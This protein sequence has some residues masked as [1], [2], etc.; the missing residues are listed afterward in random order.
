MGGSGKIY[1]QT[2][3][4]EGVAMVVTR[5][6]DFAVWQI[7]A[8]IGEPARARILLSLLDGQPKASAELAAITGLRA[9]TTSVHLQQLEAANLVTVHRRGK[10]SYYELRGK[11]IASVLERMNSLG[12]VGETLAS[13]ITERAWTARVCYDHVAG[14]LGVALHDRF[15]ELGWLQCASMDPGRD[16]ELSPDGARELNAM[17]IDLAA[18]GAR[19]RRFACPCADW[20]EGKYHLGGALG[21]ALFNLGRT[22]KWWAQ[23][24]DTRTLRISA[25]GHREIRKLC[26]P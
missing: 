15:V 4:S 1:S 13:N 20:Q 22:R 7:A 19:R 25:R 26:P 21:A 5:D 3:G 9:A 8:V 23:N 14:V 6:A 10:R 12:G 24:L 17:G 2:R 11:Q 18:A 16:Y